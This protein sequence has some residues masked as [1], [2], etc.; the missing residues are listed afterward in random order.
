MSNSIS[1]QYA[2]IQLTAMD[3]CRHTLCINDWPHDASHYML[4]SSKHIIT[5]TGTLDAGVEVVG[6]HIAILPVTPDNILKR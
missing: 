4:R 1:Q 5:I 3:G 2:I 6:H